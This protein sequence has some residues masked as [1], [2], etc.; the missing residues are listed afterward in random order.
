MAIILLLCHVQPFPFRVIRNLLP[1]PLINISKSC[2][3]SV[4]GRGLFCR[5]AV[6]YTLQ[7]FNSSNINTISHVIKMQIFNN[8]GNL[9]FSAN[10]GRSSMETN[11]YELFVLSW[12]WQQMEMNI[13]RFLGKSNWISNWIYMLT[14]WW[15]L[16]AIHAIIAIV[17]TVS[18][19]SLSVQ[20]IDQSL[21]RLNVADND[22]SIRY[23]DC[24]SSP[25]IVCM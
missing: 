11:R 3:N 25:R 17:L 1:F 20:H 8:P 12:I 18:T 13:C 7:L 22:C 9:V 15:P 23:F 10:V 14:G 19:S 4:I 2:W 6:I 16:N 5:N 24:A 21:Q